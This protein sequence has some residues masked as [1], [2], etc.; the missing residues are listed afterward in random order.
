MTA[1]RTIEGPA[2]AELYQHFA[3]RYSIT[4]SLDGNASHAICTPH[5]LIRPL[6]SAM[7]AVRKPGASPLSCIPF[8]W[9]EIASWRLDQLRRAVLADLTEFF[10]PAGAIDPAQFPAPEP[11]EMAMLQPGD[12]A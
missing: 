12:A 7:F 3:G 9:F 8:G 6:P 1:R 2:Y 11:G 5:H 10:I 4:V